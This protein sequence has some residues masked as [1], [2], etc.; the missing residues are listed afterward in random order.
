MASPAEEDVAVVPLDPHHEQ[1]LRLARAHQWNRAQRALELAAR[2]R[3]DGP[4]P[5]DLASVRMVRRQLR[6]LAKWPRD[7]PAHVELGR[8]YMELEL[9][10]DAERAY[11]RAAA[12]APAEPAAYVY[13]ALEYAYRGATAE[14]ERAYAEARA[15]ADGLPP[16]ADLLAE[17][18]CLPAE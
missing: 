12:L 16:L 6:V 10:E 7:A 13:L 3:P 11:L 1:G 2:A 8:A 9:G 14:A 5:A 4:A 18:G 17:Q 15:R